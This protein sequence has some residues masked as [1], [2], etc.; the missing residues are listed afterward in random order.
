M[1]LFHVGALGYV[2]LGG[3]ANEDVCGKLILQNSKQ[4]TSRFCSSQAL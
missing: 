4:Q 3:K 2:L 1:L